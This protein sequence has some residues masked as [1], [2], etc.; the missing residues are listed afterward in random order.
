[1]RDGAVVDQFIGA[2][3]EAQVRAFVEGLAPTQSEADLLAAAGAFYWFLYR[4]LPKTSGTIETFVSQ[5]VEVDRDN[6]GVPHIKAR[7]LDDAW[8]VEGYTTAED[9]MFQMDAVAETDVE[10]RLRLPVFMIRKLAMF[11]LDGLPVDRYL[12][13]SLIIGVRRHE[14]TR[15]SRLGPARATLNTSV[16]FH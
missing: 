8:F 14:H 7:T 5:P 1:M 3:P 6:L 10:Q 4:A 13:H 11:K 15:R 9:R 16:P 12:R 2:V